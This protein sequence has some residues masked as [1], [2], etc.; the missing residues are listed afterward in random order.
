[1]MEVSFEQPF[2]PPPDGL[3]AMSPVDSRL[4]FQR[5]DVTGG[6]VFYVDDVRLPLEVAPGGAVDVEVDVTNERRTVTPLNDAYCDTGGIVSADGLGAEITSIP[7]WEA[8]QDTQSVCVGP[9]GFTPT[10]ETL[11]FEYQA[12]AATGSYSVEIVGDS[13]TGGGQV[14]YEIAV[15]EEAETRPGGG[16]R[17]DEEEGDGGLNVPGLG[18]DGPLGISTTTIGLVALVVVLSLLLAVSLR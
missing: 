8:S 9:A 16:S 7:S 3:A 4:V 11:V 13:G 2:S 15:V 12:P 10:T 1:M 5:G 6:P 17:D 18:G 14:S